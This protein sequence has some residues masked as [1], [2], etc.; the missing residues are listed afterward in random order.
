MNKTKITGHHLYIHPSINDYVKRES[1]GQREV[2]NAFCIP[3]CK[4]KVMGTLLAACSSGV[5]IEAA[6]VARLIV[7][8]SSL[9]RCLHIVTPVTHSRA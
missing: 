7:S 9:L 8:R 1:E 4:Y 5:R 3:D 6:D 2:Y